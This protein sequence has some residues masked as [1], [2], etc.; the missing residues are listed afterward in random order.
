MIKKITFV[1]IIVC[2]YRRNTD[3]VKFSLNER[4]RNLS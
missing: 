1:R 2:R 4:K 3:G